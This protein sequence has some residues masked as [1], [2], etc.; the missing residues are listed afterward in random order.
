[1]DFTGERYLPE[2][3]GEMRLEHLHRY[4][5][6]AAYCEGC[7][8]LDVACGEGY[9]SSL[10]A[11]R[12][13]SVIG[14]DLSA[15]AVR[16]ASAKYAAQTNLQ[17]REGS[18]C[19]LPLE[20]G[21]VERIVSFETIEHLLEQR[22]MLSEFRRV[23]SP[24]G[25]LFLSS[26]NRPV[27]RATREGLNEFHVRELDRAELDGL[28][29]QHFAA[30]TYLGQRA[31]AGSILL[32]ESG[33]S[34]DYEAI[35]DHGQDDQ[36][37]RGIA[38]LDSPV[39]Y[40]AV[41]AREAGLLP[42]LRASFA[43]SEVDDP[44][45]R[46]GEVAAWAKRL[47]A[48]LEQARSRHGA[49]QREFD[50][51]SARV[52]ALS[53]ELSERNAELTRSNAE[54][55]RLVSSWSWWLTRPLRFAARVA[56]GDWQA[57]KAGLRTHLVGTLR[58]LYHAVPLPVA[59]R[60]QL[61]TLA[62]RAAGR[63]F[64]GYGPYETWR[65]AHARSRPQKWTTPESVSDEDLAGLVLPHSEVP[66]VSIIIPTY[67][68]LPL[69]F[70]CLRSIAQNPPAVRVEVIIAE[71]CSGDPQ[72]SRLAQVRGLRY[73]VN[74]T[75]LGFLRSCNRAV[76]FARGE[77]VYLLNNDTVVLPGWLDAMLACFDRHSDCGLVGSKLIFADGRL[78]E[79]GGI[80]WTDASAW[81][82]GR[83]Q[84]PD[85]PAFNYVK[86][87]DYCSGASILLRKE[88]FDSLGGFDQ[89]YVPAYCEDSD[90]A[91]E[92]R[93]HGLKVL[94]APRSVVVHFEG[95]THGTDVSSGVKSHQLGNQRKFLEKWKNVLERDQFPNGQDVFLARDRSR[96]KRCVLVIDH[97]VPQPDR[98]AGSRTMF[99]IIEALVEDGFNV[100]FWPQ[101]LWLDPVYT[102]PLQ[103]IGVEVFYGPEYSDGFERW[104]AEN[105]KYIDYALL[106]RPYVALEFIE[107]LRAHSRAQLIYYGHD[108]HHLRIRRR[109][110]LAGVD[111]DADP[112]RADFQRMEEK[113]W[114][115]V[116]LIYYPI[117]EETAHVRAANATY[118]AR[119]LPP[120]GFR[121]F[122]D[123]LDP[124]LAQRRDLLFV[125][126]FGHPPNEDAAI[127]FVR[128][129]FPRVRAR[130]P[131]VRVWIVGSAS[132]PQVQ[133]LAASPD[134]LVTGF[135][136]EEQLQSHYANARVVVAPLRYGAGLKGKVIEAMR[137]GVPVV[138][139]PTGTQGMAGIE[140][141]I[142]VTDD[143][144]AFAQSVV[145]LIEDDHRWAA[146]RHAQIEFVKSRFSTENLRRVLLEDFRP[147]S[148]V[149]RG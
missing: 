122:A 36:V 38:R 116:D 12:A 125:G 86:E 108:I 137:F 4:A 65:A 149:P 67:G 47:D 132:P 50:D 22:A 83:L 82:F 102:P 15:E 106:S 51:R 131:G 123:P 84:D 8:V 89:R 69:T 94:Y 87:A 120:Y 138:T 148:G 71:N 17:F 60:A 140:R 53:L 142:P 77:Y 25:L 21:C 105:G 95:L 136:T 20:D 40:V 59:A 63:L 90:L 2:I 129:I 68:K 46:H 24:R 130:C 104:I 42:A 81:N 112:E 58:A 85:L 97:Y 1:M 19:A 99:Q 78:Q 45:Q 41:C 80:I 54:L 107:A 64:A 62:F 66:L 126:G 70:G 121:S 91:F 146:Q 119:T 127:W 72:M 43:L 93:R 76:S 117:E 23:L 27:Y 139:T 92:V 110:E 14:V 52:S 88:L 16:H 48:E 73:E 134:V 30:V 111:P 113:V 124:E 56:R 35:V 115:S 28:L 39:Y 101:N 75:N 32:P 109:L 103:D 11:R 133:S 44:V 9:G 26:P 144:E 98:D 31:A 55:K 6:V 13:K 37:E 3:G 57:V 10:L 143:P 147:A 61:T 128:E 18:V 33:N 29:R 49:L 100:K 7:T 5:W 114:S 34:P 118:R 145:A 96:G 74:P 135:V 141:D 79:A